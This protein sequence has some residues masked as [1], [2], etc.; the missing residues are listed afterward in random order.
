MVQRPVSRLYKIEGKEGNVNSDILN[1]DNVNKGSDLS[2]NSNNRPKREAASQTAFIIKFFKAIAGDL[3]NH[4]KSGVPFFDGTNFYES[5]RILQ[6]F[7]E[8][9]ASI[10][11]TFFIS[12]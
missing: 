11:F 10:L 5:G 6:F 12:K 3:L 4:L 8:T 1:K 7:L 2:E 9:F